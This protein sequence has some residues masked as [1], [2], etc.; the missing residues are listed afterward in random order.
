MRG[1][2]DFEWMSVFESRVILFSS[3]PCAYLGEE[4]NHVIRDIVKVAHEAFIVS[5]SLKHFRIHIRS[6][7][8]DHRSAIGNIVLESS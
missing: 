6:V 2:V 4:L 5:N 7:R 3:L 8:K 1:F